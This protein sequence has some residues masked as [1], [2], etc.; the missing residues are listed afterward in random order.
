MHSDNTPCIFGCERSDKFGILFT[1]DGAV[2][3]CMRCGESDSLYNYLIKINRR[4]LIEGFSA[5]VKN[6][7]KSL[8]KVVEESEDRD[9]KVVCL[10]GGY[11][12]IYYDDYL[13]RR[14]FIPS[15]YKKYHIG[16]STDHKLKNHLI[17]PIYQNGELKSWL[18]RSRMS[19]EW[20]KQNLKDFKN[21]E[22]SLVLRYYNSEGTEFSE[23]VGNLDNIVHSSCILVEGLFDEQNV[24]NILKSLGIEEG[25]GFTFG[26]SLSEEQ[27]DLLV[28]K[29]IKD[30]TLMYDPDA[31]KEIEKYV[32]KYAHR[33][34]NIYGVAL[35]GDKDPGDLSIEEFLLY[36][37]NKKRGL[38]FYQTNLKKIF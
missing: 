11:T 35:K 2:V 32:M 5:P 6:Q 19:K 37:N 14:G 8:E 3:T 28:E 13:D 7:L 29:G 22:A 16:V 24:S 33:F 10:P 1:N 27:V 25:C 15:D 21:K 18:A 23:M 12:R 20:H 31:L 38:E 4:D 30:L 9:R 26:K 36:Y 17:F 34:E